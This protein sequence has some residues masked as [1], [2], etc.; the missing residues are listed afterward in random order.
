MKAEMKLWHPY[1]LIHYKKTAEF[2]DFRPNYGHLH[3]ITF[4]ILKKKKPWKQ[5]LGQKLIGL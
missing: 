1:E 2:V 4:N 5:S 3:F